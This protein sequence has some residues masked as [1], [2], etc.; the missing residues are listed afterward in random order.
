[1]LAALGRKASGF[2]SEDARAYVGAMLLVE[3]VTELRIIRKALTTPP[4]E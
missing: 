2:E 3:A 1:V 4:K